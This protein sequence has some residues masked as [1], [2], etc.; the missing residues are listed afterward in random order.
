MDRPRVVQGDYSLESLEAKVA[1]FQRLTFEERYAHIQSFLDF[2][3]AVN[4]E[5]ARRHEHQPSDRVR[6]L[7][8]P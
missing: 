1:W 7:R 8:L 4:P 6:I 3:A 2:I 5:L